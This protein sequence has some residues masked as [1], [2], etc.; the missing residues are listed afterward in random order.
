MSTATS[1][2]AGPVSPAPV[3]Q[4]LQR[5]GRRHRRA[6]RAA[7]REPIMKSGSNGKAVTDEPVTALLTWSRSTARSICRAS[8]RSAWPCPTTT[9]S[10]ST[11]RTSVS[12]PSSRTGQI[13][14]YN[15]LVGGGMGMTH[16][17]AKPFPASP[18]PICYVPADRVSRAAEAV[19]KLFRDHGNRAD[20]KRARIKYVVHDWGDR[21]V[22]RRCCPTI[23]PA[24]W[25]L[26]RDIEV[27]GVPVAPRLASAGRRQVV[28][29]HHRR[30]RPHQ[31][32]WRLPAAHGPAQTHRRV[33]V[34]TSA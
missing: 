7:R 30:E 29:R 10:T 15:M 27:T 25:L 28:L 26:P 6:L 20:R 18:E 9:A 16:G 23:S 33:S 8:S 24:R 34:R 31:G 1:W 11:P 22:S 3:Y 14:G 12:W 5:R 19:I 2:P 13:V 32:R 21:E 17:N 4:E